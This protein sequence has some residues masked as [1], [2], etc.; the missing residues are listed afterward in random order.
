MSFRFLLILIAY[1]FTFSESHSQV[2]SHRVYYENDGLVSSDV[3]DITQSPDGTMWFATITGVSQYDGNSWRNF[4]STE[5]DLPQNLRTKI[6]CLPDSTVWIAGFKNGTPSISFWNNEKWNSFDMPS[7][8]SKISRNFAFDIWQKGEEFKIAF[9][10]YEIYE[11]SSI[12]QRWSL[13]G[14]TKYILN[15]PNFTMKLYYDQA[16]NLWRTN[17]L[18]VQK[19][20]NDGWEQINMDEVIQ[21]NLSIVTFSLNVSKQSK[22]VYVLG[23][24]WLGVIEN[25][26][27]K[28]ISTFSN[29]DFL[30]SSAFSH[31]A[32][33]STNQLYFS[34]YSPVYTLKDKDNL[35]VNFN[36][37]LN[38]SIVRKIFIDREDNIW[39][40]TPRGAVK[41][42]NNSFINYNKLSGLLEDEVSAILETRDKDILL[43]SNNSFTILS[44]ES[45][46]TKSINT[47]S[48]SNSLDNTRILKILE[49]KNNIYFVGNNKGL[50][51]W[52][53]KAPIRWIKAPFR[54]IPRVTEIFMYN[55]TLYLIC[56]NKIYKQISENNFKEIFTY[57]K[58]IRKAQSINNEVLLMSDH[59]LEFKGDTISKKYKLTSNYQETIYG[60]C[61]WNNNLF[62]ATRQGLQVVRG[63][64]I[65][66]IKIHKREI[67]HAVYA[68]LVDSKN[69]FWVGT[70]NGV[71]QFTNSQLN[72]FTENSGLIGNEIN[73]NALIEDN[74]GNIWI[75]TEK[76][77]S[78]FSYEKK[79]KR[80]SPSVLIKS[81]KT[82]TNKEIN[83]KNNILLS[84]NENTLEFCFAGVS[85]I[86]EE[87]INYR[88]KLN[89]FSDK[90]KYLPSNEYPKI[91][92]TNL[93]H[94]SYQFEVQARNGKD[95]WSS[96]TFSKK[97]SISR[98]FIQSPFFYILICLGAVGIGVLLQAFISQKKLQKKLESKIVEKVSQIKSSEKELQD[99]NEELSQLNK[100]L[101][102]FVY[103]ASHDLKSPLNSIKGLIEVLSY[104][105][106]EE[107]KDEFLRLMNTSI[108]NLRNFIDDLEALARNKR[109]SLSISEVDFE[110]LIEHCLSTIQFSAELEDVS[111][112]YNVNQKNIFKSD[113]S[114]IGVV[115][116][117]LI[118]NGIRYQKSFIDDPFVDIN[119][120]IIE[121]TAKIS[122][123]D[124]GIGIP[125]NKIN[126][127]F[128]MFEKGGSQKQGSSGLG[129]FIVKETIEKLKGEI[130]VESIE[131]QGSKFTVTLPSLN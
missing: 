90:W 57:K 103:T 91:R 120:D 30:Q 67:N 50:G 95:K 126:K 17:L 127:I 10:D 56:T 44:D 115:L 42:K 22:K 108:D 131:G 129:L 14:S 75:G 23:A 76:G 94:G 72:H 61:Q 73:R 43:A 33:S 37:P 1:L 96:S 28:I 34:N 29:V 18:G 74:K 124:N 52:D 16:G 113:I 36:H 107:E 31:I 125:K 6:K 49:H 130:S 116:N 93:K 41:L 79:Q 69:N 59:I 54:F 112:K 97:F 106:S 11:Y 51:V 109:T 20:N 70:S 71:Y 26:K 27:V 53:K 19:K 15:S 100:E 46:E 128:N 63:D 12:T 78:V 7:M 92:I 99:K 101:D 123:V 68:L 77:V 87:N 114:R 48:N 55:D 82:D 65:T 8:K 9:G 25:N 66:P 119:V 84:S 32:F 81:I 35:K 13:I 86:D 80:L 58:N 24:K 62:V 39:L 110:Q 104:A 88:Y 121:N 85:F 105:D 21:A 102:K 64:S 117:N 111:I 38:K 47:K 98:S 2:Y 89:G 40:A 5:F 122:V 118:S 4:H 45:F 60:A 3:T 83:N